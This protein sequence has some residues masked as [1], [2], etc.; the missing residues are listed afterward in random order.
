MPKKC[1]EHGR[2]HF[3]QLTHKVTSSE[4]CGSIHNTNISPLLLLLFLPF[5]L[6]CRSYAFFGGGGEGGVLITVCPSHLQLYRESSCGLLLLISVYLFHLFITVQ[7]IR[8]QM[9][10]LQPTHSSNSSGETSAGQRLP[11]TVFCLFHLLQTALHRRRVLP[12]GRQE[13]SL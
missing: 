7:R 1:V 5:L 12:H 6:C 13:A 9:C 10:W 4:V 11:L 2:L 8:H 3:V